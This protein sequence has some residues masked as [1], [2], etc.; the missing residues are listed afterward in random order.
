[1]IRRPIAAVAAVMLGLLAGCAAQPVATPEPAAP[2]DANARANASKWAG[3]KRA[4]GA[5][6]CSGTQ[7][8]GSNLAL[9]ASISAG[10]KLGQPMVVTSAL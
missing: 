2:V 8:S 7:M 6:Q 1:M 9:N 5:T 3:A 4:P 10:S